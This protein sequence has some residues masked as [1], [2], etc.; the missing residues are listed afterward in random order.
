[1]CD[2][3]GCQALPAI[4][5]LTQEHDHVANLVSHVRAA[6]ER[7]DVPEMATLA[8]Q[9]AA[10]LGP[11]TTVEEEGLFPVLA[12][13]F[14]GQCDRLVGE[15]RRIEQVLG[16]AADGV[17]SDPDWPGRLMAALW[18]LREH[19]LDEQDDV[20]PTAL[21]RLEPADWDAVDAIRQRVAT[22]LPAAR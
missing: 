3:C 6:H 17:P 19:I 7:G 8:T 13:E 22:T 14:S 1:M 10:V 15:H 16:E 5:L 20:F 12:G 11:H 9:I 2:C 4:S 21:S 18:Q